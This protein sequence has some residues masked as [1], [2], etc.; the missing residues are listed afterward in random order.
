M[1][2]GVRKPME[3]GL[4]KTCCH[5]KTGLTHTPAKRVS[6]L[7][8]VLTI[9]KC[10]GFVSFCLCLLEGLWAPTQGEKPHQTHPEAWPQPESLALDE[11]AGPRSLGTLQR[12]PHMVP[13]LGD[14]RCNC[15]W[16][17]SLNRCVIISETKADQANK[18]LH[19]SPLEES[20][21]LILGKRF[22]QIQKKSKPQSRPR[23]SPA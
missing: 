21:H 19:K 3:C 13:R 10:K 9:L 22:S 16:K 15:I 4:H 17:Q 14:H 12:K 5:H 7:K 18:R 11:P 20:S 2:R 6:S 8:P 23:H 1:D